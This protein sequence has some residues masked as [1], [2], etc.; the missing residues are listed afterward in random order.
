M[1][2]RLLCAT[3]VSAALATG[4][5]ATSPHPAPAAVE[6]AAPPAPGDAGRR[7][8]PPAPGQVAPTTVDGKT[9]ERF[10]ATVEIDRVPGGKRFQGT[11]LIRDDGRIHVVSYRPKPEWFGFVGK[12]VMVAAVDNNPPAHAQQIGADHVAVIDIKLVDNVPAPSPAL[13]TLPAA[14]WVATADALA[15][16]EHRWV[17]VAVLAPPQPT[18]CDGWCDVALTLD[19]GGGIVTT[20]ESASTWE[21]SFK[22]HVGELVTVVGRVSLEAGKPFIGTAAVCPG[23]VETCGAR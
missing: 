9:V 5:P 18:A 16:L 23:R 11:W 13:S 12:R 3:F 2:L 21:R 17:S 4:C 19:G 14:P 7:K 22:G 8:T 6:P 20:R 1:M 15:K 10:V